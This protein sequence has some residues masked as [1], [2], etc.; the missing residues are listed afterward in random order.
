M[1]ESASDLN[2]KV[3]T[4]YLE[5]INFLMVLLMKK[6]LKSWTRLADVL[7]KD[8]TA[9]NKCFFATLNIF[10]IRLTQ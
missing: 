8:R 5:V 9:P 4:L 1:E 6:S 10:W 2:I 7:P 3:F